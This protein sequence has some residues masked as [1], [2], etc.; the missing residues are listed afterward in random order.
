MATHANINMVE[1]NEEVLIPQRKHCN[2]EKKQRA[3]PLFV[4]R[5][6]PRLLE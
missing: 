2:A 5:S 3:A 4:V 6:V 1:S